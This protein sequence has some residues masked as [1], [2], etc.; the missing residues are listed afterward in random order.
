MVA[1]ALVLPAIAWGVGQVASDRWGWS[2]WLFWIPA[3]VPF[4]GALA[5]A[6]LVWRRPRGSHAV[7]HGRHAGRAPRGRLSLVALQVITCSAVAAT[8]IPTL[9]WFS[10]G[11]AAA[12][13]GARSPSALRIVHLNA[14]WPGEAT[15]L[16]AALMAQPADVYAISEAGGLLRAPAVRTAADAGAVTMQVGRFAI[17]SRCPVREARAIYDDGSIAASWI[18]FGAA[19]RWPE[20]SMLMVDAPRRLRLSREEIFGKL[21]AALDGMSLGSPDVVVGDLNTTPGSVAVARTWPS[22]SDATESA[23]R[24]LRATFPREFPLWAIDRCL[25]TPQWRAVEW[26]SWDP[27]I[28]AH[29]GQRITLD[30]APVS[31]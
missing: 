26:C 27:G 10:W 7:T 2:Q 31:P 28:G 14:R 5:A 17:V 1:W 30:P 12:D 19:G 16:G 24:G 25:V 22:L 15:A 21:R 23:G 29:R 6:L 11:L 18:R 4:A 20:W 3:V 13:S 8:G 9:R